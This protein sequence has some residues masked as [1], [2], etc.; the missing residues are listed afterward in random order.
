MCWCLSSFSSF[1]LLI[2]P[3][4]FLLLISTTKTLLH[5]FRPLSLYSVFFPPLSSPPHLLSVTFSVLPE[6]MILLGSIE[7]AQLQSLLSRQLGRTKRLEYIKERALAEKKRFSVVSFPGSDD[8]S[9][10]VS[11]EVRFQVR[12]HRKWGWGNYQCLEWPWALLC[13]DVLIVQKHWLD[14]LRVNKF[15]RAK[16]PT[17]I[18]KL[19]R[20]SILIKPPN[21]LRN[22]NKAFFFKDSWIQRG[23][24]SAASHWD[25]KQEKQ[26]HPTPPLM[27]KQIL[28]WANVNVI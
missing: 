25:S 9:Q 11:Q 15:V 17:A 20:I 2:Y 4:L 12:G 6:S 23:R 14:G 1:S 26:H 10:R 7:R 19:S 22:V 13:F 3:P 16:M 27:S 8:E 18:K 28:L 24:A 21:C 5:P